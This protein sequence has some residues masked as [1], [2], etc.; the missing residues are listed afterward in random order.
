MK[1][2]F[3]KGLEDLLALEIVG[4]VL[5]KILFEEIRGRGLAYTPRFT[6][7]YELVCKI[8]NKSF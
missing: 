7:N 4:K 6:A 1:C 5:R 2:C 3:F 8:R